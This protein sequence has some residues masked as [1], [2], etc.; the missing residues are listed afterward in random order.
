M[1]GVGPKAIAILEK[2]LAEEGLAFKQLTIEN[3]SATDF[4]VLC[5]LD[6]DNAPKKRLIRDFLI[7]AVAGNQTTLTDLLTH[8]FR[9]ILPGDRMVDSLGTFIDLT[10]REKIAVSVLEIHSIITHGKEGAAHGTITT[11]KGRKLYFSVI[12]LFS[13]NQKEAL[14]TQVTA[15]AIKDK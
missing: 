5:S 7:A 9:F 6:C 3:H 13:G 14:I 11:K 1:H 15:F 10:H 12:V 8:H 4:A 2:A